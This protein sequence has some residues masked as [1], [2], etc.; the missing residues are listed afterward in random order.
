MAG[1]PARSPARSPARLPACTVHPSLH[2][3]GS[4]LA[5]G[6]APK[7]TAAKWTECEELGKRLPRSVPTLA[8]S[9]KLDLPE[10][11]RQVM[12]ERYEGKQKRFKGD[13]FTAD[14]EKLQRGLKDVKVLHTAA[15][16]ELTQLLFLAKGRWHAQHFG[17]G[18]L[19]EPQQPGAAIK[20]VPWSEYKLCEG[21]LP[22]Q[23]IKD[24]VPERIR[25]FP[26]Y[27]PVSDLEAGILRSTRRSGRSTE[28]WTA[29]WPAATAIAAP[30]CAQSAGA[31][32]PRRCTG[33]SVAAVFADDAPAAPGVFGKVVA[34]MRSTFDMLTSW[35]LK[36]DPHAL[37]RVAA[38]GRVVGVS[39]RYKERDMEGACDRNSLRACLL[40]SE[41]RCGA[42]RRQC[43]LW[44]VEAL[45]KGKETP[46]KRTNRE[47]L[48]KLDASE[49]RALIR[50]ST[51]PD[52]TPVDLSTV[53]IT[54][55]AV[56]GDG[57]H[58]LL[59]S[60]CCSAA[61]CQLKPTR[62]N[63]VEYCAGCRRIKD[64]IL[65]RARAE[66]GTAA[67]PKSAV[68]ASAAEARP[69]SGV[70]F[71][72]TYAQGPQAVHKRMTHMA[73]ETVRVAQCA[74]KFLLSFLLAQLFIVIFSSSPFRG[75]DKLNTCCISICERRSG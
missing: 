28:E 29:P 75:T 65:K 44:G 31:V 25:S 61:T 45:A 73:R 3:P 63:S 64:D 21:P 26:H 39:A 30:Q 56:L 33:V 40:D 74:A 17:L 13:R 47:R 72:T 71:A 58:T 60:N 23:A 42:L 6:G 68:A 7:L 36:G 18:S 70:T 62:A 24:R 32:A 16:S 9:N 4:R 35:E 57:G 53:E 1:E 48:Q 59:Y 5:Q 55:F 41:S 34:G 19:A 22:L 12:P 46:V 52:Q 50:A 14:V 27:Y 38:G 67:A 2:S 37:P 54:K 51:R 15:T 69:F 49:L 10:L 66:R 43:E 20:L 11:L 8:G